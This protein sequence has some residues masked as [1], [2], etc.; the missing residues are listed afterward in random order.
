[1]LTYAH[2]STSTRIRVF[3]QMHLRVI[4]GATHTHTH[5]H[6]YVRPYI[7][8]FIPKHFNLQHLSLI[9]ERK[10]TRTCFW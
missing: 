1:M 10:A 3:L 2:V 9:P 4:C 6:A 8:P 5:K 7:H